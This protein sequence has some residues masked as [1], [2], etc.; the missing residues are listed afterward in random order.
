MEVTCSKCEQQIE[1]KDKF[2]KNCG[3]ALLLSGGV[4]APAGDEAA[5][6]C[7]YARKLAEYSKNLR[8][9]V[10]L[11]G[12]S[13]TKITEVQ[14]GPATSTQQPTLPVTTRSPFVPS[15][16]IKELA[17]AVSGSHRP[18]SPRLLESSVLSTLRSS[19]T[20][21]TGSV[22]RSTR[23]RSSTDQNSNIYNQPKRVVSPTRGPDQY[24]HK[25]QP[26]CYP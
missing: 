11:H 13:K 4:K 9:S 16:A 24:C 15:M 25:Y 7:E 17:K 19:G 10:P 26:V 12:K 8:A 5:Q 20:L 2:C 14:I 3:E 21:S 22:P 18:T 6:L 23:S 1:V